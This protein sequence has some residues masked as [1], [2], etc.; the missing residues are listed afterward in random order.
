MIMFP[1][2]NIAQKIVRRTWLFTIFNVLV[3]SALLC[4]AAAAQN[5]NVTA[6]A[7]TA[8]ASYTTLKG[9]FDAINAGTHQGAITVNI[10]LSTTEGATPAV[11]NSNGAGSASYTSVLI[12]PSADGVTVAGTTPTGRGVIELNGADNVTI[13]GDNPNTA[14]TNRNLTIQSTATNTTAFTSLVRIALAT[15]VVTSAD[16]NTIK[17]LN[18]IGNA[19]GR[20]I[21]G[22]TSTT[23]SENTVYGVIATAGASTVAATTAPS[24]I[25]SVATTIGSP[26]TAAN[27]LI[28]NNNIQT[29]ARGIAVQ[30]AATTVFPGMVISNNLVGNAT[31][32][33]VDQVYSVG[34]TAQGSANGVVSRN[35]VYIESFLPS[36]TSAANRAID[37]GGISAT[38]T[39]TVERNQ[40]NRAK[41]NAPDF[42]LAHGININGGT[43]SVV[44]NNFIQN[45]T[46]NS[47]SG[48]FYSTTF[49]VAGIRL[50]GGTGHQVYHNS[51]NLTGTITGATPTITAGLMITA[52]TITGVDARNN[53]FVN[54]LTNGSA[55]SAHVAVYLPPSGTAAMNLTLNNN[56]YFNSA[57]PAATQ[58]VG[59]VGT[60]AGTG[61]YTQANF[62][63]STTAGT[64]NFRNYTSTLSAGAGNDS[65]S[66][67]V[68]PQFLSATD[69][70]IAPAS[71]MVDAG[72]N[73]GVG[74]DIDGQARVPPPDIG[75]DEPGGVT[76][77]TNDIAAVA[78][79][80]PPSGSTRGAGVAFA[81]QASFVNNGTAAQASV[82]VR[83]RILDASTAVVYNQTTTIGPINPGQTL[84]ATFPNATLSAGTYTTEASSELVGDEV[85][86][87]NTV[88]GTVNV[89]NP[90]AGGTYTV[91]AGGNFPSL[92]NAGGIFEAINV[93]GASGNLVINITS[94]LTGE[95]GANALNAISG[96]FTVLIK[97][98]GAARTISGTSASTGLI[99][100]NGADNV[101][102]DG[103][104]SG[105]TD[106]SLTITN[107]NTGATVIWI[108]SAGAAD[109]ATGNTV[110]NVILSGNTGATIIA[111][112]LAGSGTTFGGDAESPNSNNTIQNTRI[113]R[114]QNA[115]FLRGP[116]AAPFDQN[117]L[118]TGNDWGSTVAA[119]KLIFRGMLIGNAQNFTVSNNVINGI[120]STTTTSS[121]M[122]GIQIALLVNGGTVTGNKISDVKHNNTTGWGSN[123]IYF[124]SSSAASNVTVANNFISDVASQGFNGQ[125]DTDNGYGM[126]V[127]LGGGY[128]IYHNSILLNTNQGAG[129]AAGQTAGINILTGL[130]AGAVDLRDN[131]FASTQTLGTRY[132]VICNS[133]NTVFSN[134]NYNDYFAQN[135]GFI[136]GSARPTLANWQTGT[137]Q[138]ANSIAVNPMFVTTTAPADL[139]LQTGSTLVNAGTTVAGV[140]TDIDG[141][142][143]DATP[144]IGADELVADTPGTLQFSSATYSLAENASSVASPNAVAGTATITVTRTGGTV[145][146]MPEP[147]AVTVIGTASVNYSTA[148]GTAVGGASCGANVDYVST[149]GTL[150]WGDGDAAPK[151]FTVTICDESVFENDE[152]INLA[153]TNA[154]GATLGT[155]ANA[156]LTITNDDAA[157]APPAAGSVVISEFRFRGPTFSV[158][159]GIDGARD[160]YVELYNNTGSPISVGATD[161]AG[162]TLAALSADGLTIIPIMT[163][164]NGTV[165]PAR[166]HYLAI[167]SDEGLTNLPDGGLPPTGGYSLNAYAV[168]DAFYTQDIADNAG[169]ALFR[170]ATLANLTA[171]NRL[172]AVGFNAGAAPADL[173]REGT[174]LPAP[175]PFTDG[176][177]AYVRKLTTGTPQDTNNNAADFAFVAPDAGTYGGQVA[178]RGAPGPENCGCNPANL[179]AVSSPIQRNDTV[180]AGLIDPTQASTAPP[181]RIRDTTSGGAGTPTAFGTL[182][183][184]RKFT[185]MTGA[186]VTAL[187]FRVVDITTTNSV[188]SGL[189]DMRYLTSADTTANGGTITIIGTTVQAPSDASVGGGLNA[190]GVVAIPG[191]T[192]APGSSINVRFL[193]GVAQGGNFRFFVNVEAFNGS[194]VPFNGK[195]PLTNK[196]GRQ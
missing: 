86:G 82:P 125:A 10:A 2:S 120:S 95:T 27:L 3:F 34:I 119:D 190:S 49:N 186:A 88:T 51:V 122:T 61:F 137:G 64:T 50:A 26:A 45:L 93:A 170:T 66:K 173:F 87:N 134:I 72:A 62:D 191:G 104:L 129:A 172:D 18:L 40:V 102:I 32:A 56:D 151:T 112:V 57:A 37:I 78:I 1:P 149:S 90:V 47:T 60:T 94:D 185:N 19:T 92:T 9:A 179:F 46:L 165:I 69:L 124:T 75:A 80:N 14:G 114:V 177:Y 91:G 142:T 41:N 76:P 99:K 52:T 147:N 105:G 106:R 143:R 148:N 146:G 31:A 108:A 135:V 101:T 131:I 184:R 55:T 7:G 25:S 127:A 30:G 65:A 73:V 77:P 130:A 44:R 187:R 97:P 42:W 11:L 48:G 89:V 17:N 59:Q 160:E 180:K 152:T 138:D 121:T 6:T 43:N 98:S 175:S 81:V 20:N 118:I 71:P 35:T 188:G 161:G 153:L 176:Q 181:N 155:P 171:A 157:P 68:D 178:Q 115:A 168:G 192:L 79:I 54:S 166:A 132:A 150:N 110:K 39:F 28:D 139:H 189:A 123:G 182:D 196:V 159:Q 63:P 141:Q 29:V 111:G 116:T 74:L 109:G 158:V 67:K 4:V 8:S 162:W 133:A 58:G 103:S 194:T 163:I 33:A 96:G 183:I 15:S 117:W 24:A 23:G 136:G 128:K 140:T 36:S 193:L 164:P 84:T 21:T 38:G 195:T 113:F 13:N 83:F 145:I 70:H 16:N 169:V 22:A 100:L 156:V 144:D 174:P 126:A 107:G 5:V 154:T 85:P 167:N 53:I 12:Q